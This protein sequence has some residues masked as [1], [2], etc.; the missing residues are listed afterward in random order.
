MFFG[1][2]PKTEH[3]RFVGRPFSRIWLFRSCKKRICQISINMDVAHPEDRK[4]NNMNFHP[5]IVPAECR[6]GKWKEEFGQK[7]PII[8]FKAYSG[9]LVTGRPDVAVGRGET[10]LTLKARAKI[11][12]A[13]DVLRRRP[14]GFHD[15]DMVMQSI[16]LADDIG[17]EPSPRLEL[18]GELCGT[19]KGPANLVWRAAMAMQQ[20]VS[21]APGVR[22][23]LRK[24]IPVAAGM[25]GGSADAAAVL[26]GLN[27]L[28]NAGLGEDALEEIG[29]TI[30]SDIPFCIRG[31]LARAIGTGTTLI[32]SAGSPA[33]YIV[34]FCPHIAV[35]TADVYRALA[36]EKVR[37][38][39]DMEC[40]WQAWQEGDLD[41]VRAQW[42]NIL[43]IP[44]FQMHPELESYH[45]RLAE[46][47]GSDVRMS[48]SGP[49]L[50]CIIDDESRGRAILRALSGWPGKACMVKT[51]AR[52]VMFGGEEIA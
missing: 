4:D 23:T 7:W 8:A 28:W 13:L 19:P 18:G 22:I 51:A 48:G 37:R 42:G 10:L 33:L 32:P 35:S 52:G 21:G 41:R 38:H 11:N 30:G 34:L 24:R 17:L 46:L 20:K 1:R 27:K 3:E 14:D 45:R 6:V 39:P 2:H 12:I 40:V 26:V 31:G 49:S 25:G 44:A 5:L 36:L 47:A 16:D 9:L 50:F 43:E 29:A 15:V